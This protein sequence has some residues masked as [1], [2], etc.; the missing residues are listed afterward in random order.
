MAG[1]SLFI[2]VG[3]G[4]TP[5]EAFAHPCLINSQRSIQFTAETAETNVPDC[6]D[7]EAIAWIERE[8]R[9]LSAQ[10]SGEGSLHTPD[11]EIY[12]DWVKDED[13]K[14]VRAKMNGVTGANGGGYMAGAFHLTA[15]ELSGTRGEKVNCSITL[16]SSGAVT[17]VDNA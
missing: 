12:F 15:F 16:L 13:P 8:K 10:I 2:M 5:T 3:D 1:S 6:D 17:W 7:P 4:A 9:A 11:A 14:N